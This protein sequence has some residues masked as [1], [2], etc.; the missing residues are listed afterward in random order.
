MTSKSRLEVIQTY[1]KLV[2]RHLHPFESH[3]DSL[4]KLTIKHSV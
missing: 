3:S 4:S 1:L 2:R